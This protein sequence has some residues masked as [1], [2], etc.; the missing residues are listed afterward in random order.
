MKRLKNKKI[1]LG[2]LLIA[3]I[4]FEVQSVAA[5]SVEGAADVI[6][7]VSISPVTGPVAILLFI[8]NYILASIITLIAYLANTTIYFGNNI[9]K[10]PAVMAGW[11]AMLNITN[12]GFVLGI[13]V[14]AFAT[15]L[16]MESY[17]MKQILWKLVV[18]ALLINFSLVIAGAFLSVSKLSTDIFYN[19]ITKNGQYSMGDV[20]GTLAQPQKAIK[21]VNKGWFEKIYEKAKAAVSM[22]TFSGALKIII[23]LIFQALMSFIIILTF[24]TLIVML[25]IRAIVLIFLLILSPIVW[26][27]WIFPATEKYWRQWWSEFIRWNVFAPAV[28]FFIYLAVLTRNNIEGVFTSEMTS[29]AEEALKN[30]VP[31]SE[32]MWG[33]MMNNIV[34]LSLLIGGI[35]V[36]NKFGIA[37]GSIGV[38]LAQGAGKGV[39]AWAG[40]KGIR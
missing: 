40:R 8:L 30:T 22:L 23:G 14:I 11:E 36:A 20:L 19:S 16:R 12:L 15:I 17:G 5:Q 35:Y 1:V 28:M 24:L 10:V 38:N 3:I 29:S 13:I 39:G 4:I 25:L 27:L 34:I 33:E 9:L 18:A 21:P 7:G 32:G 6:G 2:V 31:L 37:G 26:L